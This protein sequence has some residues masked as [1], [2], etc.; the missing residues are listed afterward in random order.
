MYNINKVMSKGLQTIAFLGCCLLLLTGADKIYKETDEQGNIIFTDEPK[1]KNPEKIDVKPVTT[2]SLPKPATSSKDTSQDDSESFTYDSFTITSPKNNETIRDPG[3]FKVT[4]KTSPRLKRG[5]KAQVFLDGASKGAKQKLL[6]FSLS[7]VERGTHTIE[8]KLF[9]SKGNEIQSAS[10]TVHVK[11]TSIQNPN[12]P[13]N[14]PKP[15]PTPAPAPSN[16]S[17][18]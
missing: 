7:N 6:S 13:Q 15:T 3:N 10:T 14:K 1:T 11:R 9:D 8:V 2:I 18:S 5:H 12:H 17:G 4:A 16:N